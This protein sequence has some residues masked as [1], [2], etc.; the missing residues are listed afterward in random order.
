MSDTLRSGR[1]GASAHP[2]SATASNDILRHPIRAT[3]ARDAKRCRRRGSYLRETAPQIRRNLRGE[4]ERL[5]YH[6]PVDASGAAAKLAAKLRE[7]Q[8]QLLDLSRRNR[9]LNFHPG[10]GT[11]SLAV[12]DEVSS[13]VFRVLAVDRRA[14]QFLAREEAPPEIA[15][16]LP[17]DDGDAEATAGIAL[18]PLEAGTVADRHRDT[19]LQTPL[20]GEKLQ[21]RLLRLAQQAGSALEEQG[22]NVLYLSLGAV[23]WREAASSDVVSLAPLLLLPVELQRRNVGSRHTVRLLDEDI[24]ANPSLLELAKRVF[25]VAVPAPELGED[26]DLEAYFRSVG[27]LIAPLGWQVEDQIHLGLFSFSKLLMYRDLDPSSW[28][29]GASVVDHALIKRLLGTDPAEAASG[30]P[31]RDAR[32]LDDAVHPTDT[33]QVLDAD[34]SQ[35]VAIMAAWEGASAVIE[36]PPGT[37]K[38]QTITNI[39]AECLA[40]GQRVLFVAEKSAALDVVRRRLAAVG[41]EDF[42]L[43]LHSRKTSKATVLA[44]LQ[45]CLARVEDDIGSPDVDPEELARLRARANVYARQLHLPRPAL[46]LSAYEVMSRLS[47]RP[48]TARPDFTVP[49]VREWSR[50]MLLQAREQMATFDQRLQRLQRAGDPA[51]HPWRVLAVTRLG[52]DAKQRLLAQLGAVREALAALRASAASLAA[53]LRKAEPPSLADLASVLAA[54][55]QLCQAPQ[56]VQPGAGQGGWQ[57]GWN[58]ARWLPGEIDDLVSDGGRYAALRDRWRRVF[59]PDSDAQDWSAVLERRGRGPGLVRWMGAV[60]RD[61]SRRLR[62]ASAGELPPRLELI[63]ALTAL[64]EA[65]GLRARIEA[66]VPKLRDLLAA[67]WAGLDTPWNAVQG[68]AEAARR[69]QRLAAVAALDAAVVDQCLSRREA[70]GRAVAETERCERH[71]EPRGPISRMRSVRPVPPG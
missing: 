55:R 34:S 70:L 58:D 18:A 12:V 33:Y 28:P 17:R 14:M 24:V 36:G 42:V 62:A 7:L 39:V 19:Q 30:V 15:A 49:G 54:A 56:G 32:E 2:T 69:I 64:V 37:G 52:P 11:S 47:P 38:S 48:A 67:V 26:F 51:A 46:D 43:E 8:N 29:E 13:E 6:A 25:G 22:A 35:Q 61:D 71:C 50:A 10:K 1:T 68:L 16:A 53:W 60:W 9:L 59:A 27:A 31:V 23:A 5:C 21:T 3:I 57:G 66:R 65:S 20:T 45:R 40:R 41:L 4:Q 63:D 44:E